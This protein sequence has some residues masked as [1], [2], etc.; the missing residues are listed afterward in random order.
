MFTSWRGSGE[1]PGGKPS[2][3]HVTAATGNPRET[4]ASRT[5]DSR[6]NHMLL[7]RYV[8]TICR[9]APTTWTGTGAVIISFGQ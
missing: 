7:C 5:P 4:A 6:A 8:R 1:R 9:A 3:F 2:T